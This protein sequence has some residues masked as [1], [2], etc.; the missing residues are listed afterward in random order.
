MPNNMSFSTFVWPNNP[1]S[2]RLK[3]SRVFKDLPQENSLWNP[4]Q[5]TRL[6]CEYECEGFF[7]GNDAYENF[8][9]LDTLFRN[10]IVDE[11]LHPD[12][13]PAE[14]LITK[15]ELTEEPMENFLRYRIV[16][17]EIPFA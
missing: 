6:E 16:F 13:N 15:L 11:L 17:S 12:W 8:R 1:E 14:V 7:S 2:C 3:F 5:I 4:A 10:A 9:A